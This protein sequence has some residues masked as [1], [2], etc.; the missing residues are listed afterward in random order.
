MGMNCRASLPGKGRTE[1]VANDIDRIA[2]IWQH[3]R[4]TYGQSGDFLFGRFTIA[5]AVYA[6]VVLRFRTYLCRT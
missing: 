5:D 4:T 6:P 2:Q 3:C 1:A